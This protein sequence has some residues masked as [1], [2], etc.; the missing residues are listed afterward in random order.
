MYFMKVFHLKDPAWKVLRSSDNPLLHSAALVCNAST[1][2][3]LTRNKKELALSPLLWE[4]QLYLTINHSLLL[5]EQNLSQRPLSETH[6]CDELLLA[7][8]ADLS[9]ASSSG[10]QIAARCIFI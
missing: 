8:P 2:S 6:K 3:L 4:R 7:P 10:M 1:E 5:M 9:R